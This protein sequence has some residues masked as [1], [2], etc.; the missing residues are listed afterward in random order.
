MFNGPAMFAGLAGTMSAA[1]GGPYVS[2]QVIDQA[3]QTNDAGGSVVPSSAPATRNC[4][5]QIDQATQQMQAA[6]GYVRGD[7]LFMVLTASLQ[8][9]LDTDAR[10]VV[11]AGPHAGTWD[12]SGIV[13]DTAGICWS[14][15]G[16]RA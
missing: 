9:E 14:G 7:M 5:V 3:G 8:G 4:Q 16:R 1:F 10:I 13:K 6:E 15:S 12:V 2:G 11:L